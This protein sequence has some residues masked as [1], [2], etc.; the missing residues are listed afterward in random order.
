[1]CSQ[2]Y[3]KEIRTLILVLDRNISELM[4]WHVDVNIY[5]EDYHIL[6]DV[7]I[8]TPLVY[9]VLML[10]SL[11]L[12]IHYRHLWILYILVWHLYICC[13][14]TTVYTYYFYDGCYRSTY[15]YLS[16]YHHHH[17]HHNSSTLYT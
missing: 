14:Y 3:L 4:W 11:E 12:H 7:S 6:S 15:P 13:T 9:M 8:L 17:H 10:Y 2:A 1:M 5:I 16:I